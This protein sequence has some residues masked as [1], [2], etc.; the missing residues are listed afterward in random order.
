M[1]VANPY[2]AKARLQTLKRY[3]P[4]SQSFRY[5]EFK[6]VPDYVFSGKVEYIPYSAF[7]NDR[8]EAIKKMGQVQQICDSLPNLDCGSC[9]APT[10]LAFAEDIVRGECSQDDCIVSMR[11][12]IHEY[13]KNAEEQDEK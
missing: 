13:F 4:V 3:M 9:G 2:I 12:K 11:K 1:T 7:G 10:C 8:N 5:G 6:A